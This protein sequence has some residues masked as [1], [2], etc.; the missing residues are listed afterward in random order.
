MDSLTQIVLGAA[1]GE[2]LLGRQLGN[3]ALLL[4]AI[5]GT[6]PDLDVL[7]NFISDDP[8]RQLEIHRAYSHSMFTH[9]VAAAPLA[10]ISRKWNKE[11]IP[12]KQWYLFWF[13]VLFTHALL[14]CCTTYGTRLLLPFTDYQVAF[15]NISVI[16]PLYTLPF[17]FILAGCLFI[18]RNNPLRRKFLWTSIAV[19]SAYMLLTFVLKYDVHKKFK[20]SLTTE[21][22]TYDELN[23]TPT[24]LNAILWSAIAYN[25]SVIYTSEYSFLKENEKIK[26]NPYKRNLDQLVKYDSD[27][28]NTI[29]WFSDG[30]Y[31]VETQPGDTL[32]FYNIKFGRG[33]FNTTVPDSTFMFYWKFYIDKNEVKYK[34]VRPDWEFDE[35]L[36]MLK[37]RIGL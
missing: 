22:I 23:S 6:L 1:V 29:L 20:E 18:K 17:L 21:N 15:N 32:T 35:A 31:F 10:W 11:K 9:I 5:G 33:R 27:A 12:M 25:D 26:W 2:I 24:I 19:S 37:D 30:N 14:D 28:L 4:G 16:D 13:L 36:K 3:K 8:L 7:Y 34:E